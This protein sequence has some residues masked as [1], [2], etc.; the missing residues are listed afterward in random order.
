VGQH[1]GLVN[2]GAGYVAGG[3]MVLIVFWSRI[4]G[5]EPN[6]DGLVVTG[7]RVRYDDRRFGADTTHLHFLDGAIQF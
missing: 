3:V 7:Y 4:N 2:M 5:P 1:F 6:G